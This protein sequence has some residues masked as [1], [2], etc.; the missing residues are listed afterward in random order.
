MPP[1]G[2]EPT[3]TA[4][5]RPQ[6]HALGRTAAGIRVYITSGCELNEAWKCTHRVSSGDFAVTIASGFSV[7]TF[8]AHRDITVTIRC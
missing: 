3:I 5:E 8:D 4:S 7:L 1:A 2:I 6:T